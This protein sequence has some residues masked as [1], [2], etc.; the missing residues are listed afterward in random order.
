MHKAR[1]YQID[2]KE[3]TDALFTDGVFEATLGKT[4]V[5]VDLSTKIKAIHVSCITGSSGEGTAVRSVKAV[6]DN[7]LQMFP[8]NTGQQLLIT[9]VNMNLFLHVRMHAKLVHIGKFKDIPSLEH[10]APLGED[11]YVFVSNKPEHVLKEWQVKSKDGMWHYH[12]PRVESVML[13]V[14]RII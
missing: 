10:F 1:K 13:A 5:R 7:L 3:L 9:N 6:I 12:M 14:Q 4:K 2:F 8:R 11:K